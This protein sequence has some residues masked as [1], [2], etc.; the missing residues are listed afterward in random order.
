[1]KRPTQDRS[2]VF[3]TELPP[4]ED[5]IIQLLKRD[6]AQIPKTIRGLI[7][8]AARR[9]EVAETRRRAIGKHLNDPSRQRA[10]ESKSI[11]FD[12]VDRLT[13]RDRTLLLPGKKTELARRIREQWPRGG[14]SKPEL[15]TVRGWFPEK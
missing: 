10:Q 2:K 6:P 1:M 5:Q 15:R 13:Q 12:I 3:I 4:D 8:H 7:K 14:P 11:A 9:L